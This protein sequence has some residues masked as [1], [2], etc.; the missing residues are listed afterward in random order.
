[1]VGE[2][3]VVVVGGGI[4]GTA[5]AYYL[6]RD[7]YRVTLL[8]QGELA[9]GA[10]GANPGG[11]TT[12]T[13]K[14]GLTLQMATA[15]ARI[16]TELSAELECDLE[17]VRCGGMVVIETEQEW[18]YMQQLAARQ[19]E[20]GLQV[21]VLEA[22]EVRRREPA[23]G[24]TVIGATH[25]SVDAGVNA[26]RVTV[27]LA[28]AARRL[29]ARV[30]TRTPVVGVEIH[31]G[32]VLGV[33][34]PE[35]RFPASWVINA[36][37]AQSV[38]VG[39]MV[40]VEHPITPRRGQQFVTERRPDLVRTKM[41]GASHILH[42]HV[43]GSGDEGPL[44]VGLSMRA[45]RSGNLMMG[46]TN[47]DAGDDITATVAA[48]QAVSEYVGRILPPVRRMRIARV[49]SGLRPAS[50]TGAPLLG[51]IDGPEG[52]L[53]ASG[54]GGDGVALAPISGRYLAAVVASSGKGPTIDQ[55][56]AS[57]TVPSW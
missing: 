46:S 19:R 17:Y 2:T 44:G 26:L 27:G 36:A 3:D 55:F 18:Q 37:G 4:I 43:V 9:C 32:R 15:S 16:Y 41:T 13:K 31:A 23:F 56:L 48:A 38:A 1:M 10:S 33:R 29:G 40:G 45:T 35:G 39:R 22:D 47:E 57:V 14:P 42:K 49:W 50:A 51:A 8:E 7:G 24:P 12:Q 53:I 20:Q 25:C 6:S 34:T 11:V 28:R 52:Y 21:E 5:V 54:H 30:L